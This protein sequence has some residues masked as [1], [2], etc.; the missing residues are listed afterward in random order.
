MRRT[1]YSSDTWVSLSSKHW[2]REVKGKGRR[3]GGCV[4][5]SWAG[6]ARG[7]AA[8]AS[9]SR[10]SAN[11]HDCSGPSPCHGPGSSL[12]PTRGATVQSASP[13]IVACAAPY[14]SR[15]DG[16]QTLVAGAQA[17][18]RSV[19]APHLV[20][21]CL[22]WSDRACLLHMRSDDRQVACHRASERFLLRQPV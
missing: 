10:W 13:P 2:V 5:P 20:A 7:V 17:R 21:S 11:T 4:G 3:R 22:G 1:P 8:P 18:W 14:G 9:A 19:N 6:T 12:H 15:G 16:L